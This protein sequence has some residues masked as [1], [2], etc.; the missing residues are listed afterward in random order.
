MPTEEFDTI[1]YATGRLPDT[2]GLNLEAVGVKM[3]DKGK[4]VATNEQSSVPSIFVV[5]DALS[6]G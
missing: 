4:I 1:L 5:G 3:D 2:K 6:G